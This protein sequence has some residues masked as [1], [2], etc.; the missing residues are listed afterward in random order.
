MINVKNIK[1]KKILKINKTNVILLG[2]YNKQ[3]MLITLF[4]TII[5]H[6]FFLIIYVS[7]FTI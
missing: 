2:L 6:T 4:I 1:I 3:Y 7:N 5:N